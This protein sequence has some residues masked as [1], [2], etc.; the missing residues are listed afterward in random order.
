MILLSS[1]SAG[2]AVFRPALAPLLALY[3]PPMSG[4][5]R[6]GKIHALLVVAALICAAVVI[7]GPWPLHI[8]GQWTPLF[9]WTGSGKLHTK[10]GEYPLYVSMNPSSHFSR[11][12]L[13]GQRPTGGLHG[14]GWLCTSR[15]QM[16]RLDLSG[17]IYN[18]WR[19]TDG[20]LVS[21]RLLE[22]RMLNNGQY[23]GYFD[24]TGRW[25]G[26][27]LVMDQRHDP[28]S[29]FLSGLSIENASVSLA[30]GSYGDFKAMC[31]SR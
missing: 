4:R 8:G 15:G 3:F 11:L 27:Q 2:R 28:G 7:I 10:G 26:P 20:S 23:R 17:T 18:A 21:F 30:P 29:R 22:Y 9:T 19:T 24:L 16:Q 6:F 5:A 1:S 13:D 31:T 14:I 12:Q 25:Q